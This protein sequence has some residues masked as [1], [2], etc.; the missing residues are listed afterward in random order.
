M[1]DEQQEQQ[2]G[3]VTTRT[4][5]RNQHKL[6]SVGELRFEIDVGSDGPPVVV[7]VAAVTVSCCCC[8]AIVIVHVQLQMNHKNNNNI[9]Q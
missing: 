6:V 8:P 7:V 4:T 1:A 5:D 3:I 2:H 9:T